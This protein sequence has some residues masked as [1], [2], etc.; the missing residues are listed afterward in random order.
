[1][2]RGAAVSAGLLV[3]SPQVGCRFT[4]NSYN[5]QEIESVF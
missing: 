1:M 5:F 3:D 2:G 4:N